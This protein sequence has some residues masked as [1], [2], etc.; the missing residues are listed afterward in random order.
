MDN[1]NKGVM[2]DDS[3]GRI[4]YTNQTFREMFR[5]DSKQLEF[6]DFSDLTAPEYRNDLLTLHLRRLSGKSIPRSVNFAG[7]RTD[8]TRVQ[9]EASVSMLQSGDK[10]FFLTILKDV[11]EAI[12]ASAVYSQNRDFEA[13]QRICTSILDS[14]RVSHRP[15]ELSKKLNFLKSFSEE[16]I[17]PVDAEMVVQEVVGFIQK[18]D[19]SK[20]KVSVSIDPDTPRAMVSGGLLRHLMQNAVRNSLDALGEEGHISIRAGFAERSDGVFG[21]NC[22]VHI[23]K[24]VFIELKDDGS[25]MTEEVLKRAPE[26]FFTTKNRVKHGGMG[27]FEVFQGMRSIQGYASLSS[28]PESGTVVR[29]FLPYEKKE[30]VQ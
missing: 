8:G 19:N 1:L 14:I 2:V 25:G 4:H 30:T 15:D 17:S 26:P 20:I 12:A 6:F 18:M 23:G 9:L 16:S 22:F 5:L 3:Q 13:S 21:R 11:S 10:V 28:A 29:F 27:L 7:I 24:W